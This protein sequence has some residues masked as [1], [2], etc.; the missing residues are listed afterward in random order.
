[1][2]CSRANATVWLGGANYVR[3][4]PVARVP[5]HILRMEDLDA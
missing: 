2:T 1:M 3:L 5:A 4:D